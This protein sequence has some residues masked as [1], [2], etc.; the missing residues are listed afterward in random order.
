MYNGSIPLIL[1]HTT[2]F[3][4][5]LFFVGIRFSPPSLLRVSLHITSPH[6]TMPHWLPFTTFYK[7]CH[8]SCKNKGVLT[9][10]INL[11][12]S[13]LNVFVN[14]KY[15]VW[16]WLIWVY[17]K[18]LSSSWKLAERMEMRGWHRLDQ[19]FP[20]CVERIPSDP[21]PVLRGFVDTSLY[22]LLSSFFLFGSTAPVGQGLLIHEGL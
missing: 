9:G 8:I 16:V 2:Y 18:M 21:W 13:I 3:S 4:Y 19:W 1:L 6:F 7:Y 14:E 11:F 20:K 22:W 5:K 10:C 15:S 12:F 17:Y